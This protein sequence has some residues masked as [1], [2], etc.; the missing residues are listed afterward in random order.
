MNASR[1]VSRVDR[2]LS[3]PGSAEAISYDDQ[4]S[5]FDERVGLPDN[6]VA[7]FSAA[8]VEEAAGGLV[9]EMGAGTGQLGTA[10]IAAGICYLGIDLSGEML[11]R[12]R[13]RLPVGAE[14]SLLIQ[15]DGNRDWPVADRAARVVVG[16]RSIHHLTVHHARDQILRVLCP[17]GV[18]LVGRV[19]RDDA[20]L[21]A[22]VR[23][24]MRRLVREH[25]FEPLQ[26]DHA[27]AALIDQ[28][29]RRGA[30]ALPA[31]VLTAWAVAKSPTQL[32]DDWAG[33]DGLAGLSLPDSA[34]RAI[35]AD[36]SAWT[37]V[38]FDAHA[39]QSWE[40]RRVCT[41]ARL[42]PAQT[43]SASSIHSRKGGLDKS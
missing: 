1:P 42:A 34:K 5:R 39:Q 15:A 29:C 30:A 23:R 19:E 24:Q 33:K 11:A 41:G 20:S 27:A 4:A 31:R 22:K 38:T 10:L 35:L 3:G 36:L 8:I 25:G 2:S 28:L 9:V 18:L 40:E 12:F 6:A 17:G 14:P 7:A 21:Q 37:A 32:I 16:T 13:D 26:A 43:I